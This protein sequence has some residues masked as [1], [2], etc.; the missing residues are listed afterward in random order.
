MF[1]GQNG[2]TLCACAVDADHWKQAQA[3]AVAASVIDKVRTN[4]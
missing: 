2:A 4:F 3:A 1:Y